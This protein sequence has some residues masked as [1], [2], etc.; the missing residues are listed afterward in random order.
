MGLPS[1]STNNVKVYTVS[2]SSLSRKL[3]DW[4]ARRKKRELQ[5][6]IEWTSRVELLQ[7]FEFP[8]A[9][10]KVRT[11][12]DGNFCMATG[13]YKP[14][15]R[16]FEYSDLS[17]KFERHTDS[18][19]I[20]FQILSDDWT[21]SVHLQTNRAVEFHNEG[22]MHYRVRIP[23]FGR[24]LAYHSPSCD[25]LVGG[26]GNEVFRINI[27]QGR[28]MTP[29]AT[30]GKGV[31]VVRVNPAHQLFGFGLEDGGVEFWDP[32]VRTCIGS[33]APQGDDGAE[34]SALAFRQDGLGA[35]VGTSAGHV[36]LYDL[37]QARPWQI[38]DQRF[39]LPVR[40]LEWLEPTRGVHVEA[41]EARVLSADARSIK[42]WGATSGKPFTAIEP[43]AAVNDVCVVPGSGLMLVA[44]ESSEMQSYFVP[45]LGPAP[46]WANFLENLTE[47]METTAQQHSVYDDYKFVTRRELDSLGL[48]HLVGSN[49]LKPYMHGFFVDLRL[50]ERAKSIANPFAYEEYRLRRVQEKLAEARESRIR[51]T[52][53]LPKVNRAL[54]QRLLKLQKGTAAGADAD[55]GDGEKRLGGK[56][57]KKAKAAADTATAVLGDDRFKAMFA[58][59]EFEVDEEE[60]EFKQL[61]TTSTRRQQ[62][63][64]AAAARADGD[65]SDEDVDIRQMPV[66]ENGND[67][68][69]SDD[70]FYQ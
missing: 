5:K 16:V 67:S 48:G 31:N 3:P 37:R 50:Y 30:Q 69:D 24:S 52:T 22:Q 18:E 9:S 59:A 13:V 55:A 21:K 56:Q 46:R 2:G 4:L 42:L 25:V 26:A 44:G 10:L 53:K 39:G 32:R 11:T 63:N 65:S 41:P 28:F 62:K 19:N 47:E 6:D 8:Q 1:T 12:A 17:M 20:D 36:L 58:D 15:I 35:A 34:T 51:A 14:Q 23:R 57:R 68:D 61:H 43:A 54:A 49:V 7:D 70:G 64:Q 45:Q 40:V 60:T 27:D 66:A 38:K 29:M 33:L